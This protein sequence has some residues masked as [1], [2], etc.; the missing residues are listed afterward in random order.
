MLLDPNA[1]G[2]QTVM[3]A[4]WTLVQVWRFR[5]DLI[6]GLVS[7]NIVCCNLTSCQ[8]NGIVNTLSVLR[9]EEYLPIAHVGSGYE[10][11]IWDPNLDLELRRSDLSS[12]S[13]PSPS[14]KW[15]LLPLPFPFPF[16]FP[17]KVF[18]ARTLAAPWLPFDACRLY[19]FQRFKKLVWSKKNYSRLVAP[20]L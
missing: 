15:G 20:S 13:L 10:L 14:P 18:S 5:P 11:V 8:A 19:W 17:L 4:N 2:S 1:P 3:S 9:L 12:L 6:P 7:F 16:P